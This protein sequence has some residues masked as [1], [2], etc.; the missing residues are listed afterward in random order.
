MDI[1]N[2]CIKAMCRVFLAGKHCKDTTQIQN[3]KRKAVE[4][5]SYRL[6]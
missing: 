6:K 5:E 2:P 4:N 1:K 3:A